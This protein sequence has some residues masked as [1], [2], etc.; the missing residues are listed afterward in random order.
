M[1]AALQNE[2]CDGIK[3]G[4]KTPKRDQQINSCDVKQ[5]TISVFFFFFSR[6]FQNVKIEDF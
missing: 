1:L 2:R 6:L 3:E 4:K 5:V